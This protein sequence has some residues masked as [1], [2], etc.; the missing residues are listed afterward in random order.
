M[1]HLWEK[2]SVCKAQVSLDSLA[3]EFQGLCTQ[4]MKNWSMVLVRHVSW[5]L[6]VLYLVEKAWLEEGQSRPLKQC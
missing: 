6:Q 5:I 3:E 2:E 1:V 4:A